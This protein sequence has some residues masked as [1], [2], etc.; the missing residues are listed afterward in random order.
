MIKCGVKGSS[1]LHFQPVPVVARR[2]GRFSCLAELALDA[3]GKILRA[4]VEL[5]IYVAFDI[6]IGIEEMLGRDVDQDGQ[7]HL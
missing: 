2:D 1:V 4:A 3:Q 7:M 5:D 6:L